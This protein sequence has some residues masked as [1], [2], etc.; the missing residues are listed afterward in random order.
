MCIR[1]RTRGRKAARWGFG[2]S[3]SDG[4]GGRRRGRYVD[5]FATSAER[6]HLVSPAGY[7]VAGKFD[8]SVFGEYDVGCLCFVVAQV[9]LAAW[10]VGFE[11]RYR[12]A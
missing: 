11:T 2:I 7:V 5:V 6:G 3:G 4:G 1:D 10:C 12:L 9:G 8:G